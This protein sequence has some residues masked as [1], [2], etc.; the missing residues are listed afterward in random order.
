MMTYAHQSRL[1]FRNAIVMAHLPKYL[2]Q[3]DFEIG[4]LV[5]S[6]CRDCGRHTTFPGCVDTCDIIAQIQTVLAQSIS[7]TR[8]RSTIDTTLP[9]T[10]H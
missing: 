9:A 4:Y 2:Q 1:R 5:K 3:F 6:P 7:C 8:N 10:P